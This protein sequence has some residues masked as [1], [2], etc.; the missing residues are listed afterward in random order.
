M[1]SEV[2]WF[3]LSLFR[4]THQYKSTYSVIGYLVVFIP[5]KLVLNLPSDRQ[6]HWNVSHWY[7]HIASLQTLLHLP[8]GP[9][10]EW[11]GRSWPQLVIV[12][13][14]LSH[15]GLLD[16]DVQHGDTTHAH[17]HIQ[18]WTQPFIVK[19]ATIEFELLFRVLFL[20]D[21]KVDATSCP[22]RLV[23]HLIQESSCCFILN[24]HLM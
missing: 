8:R 12:S 5:D 4:D 2:E 21:S 13:Q 17:S 15:I 1:R 6:C 22:P 16:H 20:S 10:H 14:L 23:L 9:V 3:V 24:P 7:S 18:R 11:Q 19:D